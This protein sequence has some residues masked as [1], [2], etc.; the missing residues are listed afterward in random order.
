MGKSLLG[1]TTCIAVLFLTGCQRSPGR[2]PIFIGH[3][4]PFSGPEKQIGEHARQAITLA[5]EE[6][7]KEGNRILGRPINVLHPEF[8][9]GDADKL[10]PVALRL[11]DVNRVAALLGGT[12][13]AEVGALERAAQPHEVPLVVFA[14]LPPEAVGENVFSVT[15]GL[16]FEAQTLAQ[17][18]KQELKTERI[19]LLVDTRKTSYTT[20]AA[21][22][23]KEFSKSGPTHEFTYNAASEF[24][25]LVER[26][27][28]A[29]PNAVLHAGAISDLGP[30]RRKLESAGIKIP[31]L[32]GGEINLLDANRDASNGVYVASPYVVNDSAKENAE[33]AKKY[34]ERFNQSPDVNAALAYD[35]MQVL[36]EA[37]RRAQSVER[38]K[39]DAALKEMATTPFDKSLSGAW[40]FDKSHAARRPLYVGKV[41]D[42]K[43][44]VF[45]TYT[46]EQK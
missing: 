41:E 27:K 16:A 31:I 26:V 39:I 36:F 35:A 11:V 23:D 24:P 45:K 8:P 14:G 15:A 17:Y 7:N 6:I 30:I 42:G 4:A 20:L 38:A 12:E 34:K 9:P 3:L 43:L 18:A 33:F 22:F 5:V 32:F 10:Q 44:A 2:D 1:F 29:Q 19:A 13:L 40:T 46:Q 28:K 25:D 21:L 37:M